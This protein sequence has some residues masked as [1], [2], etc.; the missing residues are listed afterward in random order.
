[1]T[2]L[3]VLRHA[4][5][6]AVGLQ[7][8]TIAACRDLLP[9]R[10]CTLEARPGITV[11]VQDSI[12]ARALADSAL[13]YAVDGSYVETLMPG[14][15]DSTGAMISR[16]GAVERAGTYTVLVSRVGYAP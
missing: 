5:T 8:T 13:A 1:M 14:V 2:L 11:R 12:T 10:L 6:A 16:F 7:L 15:F 4:A 3:S 9:P